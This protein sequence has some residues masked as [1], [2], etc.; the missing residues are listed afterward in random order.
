[1]KVIELSQHDQLDFK[2]FLTIIAQNK[3]LK[4]SYDDEIEATQRKINF[5]MREIENKYLEGIDN[6][7]FWRYEPTLSDD[8][9]FII[10]SNG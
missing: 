1:M 7:N 4:K 6:K 2:M 8:G 5:R 10:T 9:R 3:E